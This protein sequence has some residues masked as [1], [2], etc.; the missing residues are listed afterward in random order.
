MQ[1]KFGAIVV[2]GSGKLGGS[3]L[4]RHRL[5]PSIKTKKQEFTNVRLRKINRPALFRKAVTAWRSLTEAQRQ[6]WKEVTH[7][8]VFKNVF[9]QNYHPSAYQLFVRSS[10]RRF[11]F[12]PTVVTSPPSTK[13]PCCLTSASVDF[14]ITASQLLI[15]WSPVMTGLQRLIVYATPARKKG[16]TNFAKDYRI[17]RILHSGSAQGINLYN[18]YRDYCSAYVRT[19]MIY[20]FKFQFTEYPDCNYSQASY[21][22]VIGY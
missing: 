16:V 13:L 15:Y 3:S 2:A 8:F 22:N 14:N 10:L 5:A 18:Y 7:L 6:L 9:G 17:I 12:Y 1:V 4:Q 21:V 20:S 11:L 19:G